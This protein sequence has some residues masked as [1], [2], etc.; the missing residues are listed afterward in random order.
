MKILLVITKAEIG[1]AQMSVFNL[2]KG[3]K[4]RG[5]QVEVIF[6]DGD[7]LPKELGKESI[8]YNRVRFLKRTHNPLASVCFILE[9]YKFLRKNEFDVVHF[10]SSNA[11][12][13]VVGAKLANGKI[14]TIFTFRGMSILDD[15]YR[16]NKCLKNIYFWFFKMMIYFVDVPV[17]VSRR[18][19]QDAEKMGLTKKG[20]L[21][22]NGLD[23]GSL[24]FSEK[25]ETRKELGDRL[26]VSL[27]S[28]YVLGTIGRLCYAKNYEFLINNFN[29]ILKI[30]PN[31]VLL[32]IGEGEEKR[33]YE[34]LIKENNVSEK[35]F[36]MGSIDNASRFIK[37]FDLFVLPSRYEGLS[38]TL[39][40]T[41][42]S[43]IPAL[44][45]DVGGNRENFPTDYELYELD[46]KKEFLERFEKLQNEEVLNK[47]KDINERQKEMFDIKNTVNNYEEIYK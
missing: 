4:K 30:K 12:F 11:L 43:G 29:D 13:G 22:Y 41:L 18:N 14:K 9:M 10:N 5:H 1:G 44:V 6:G 17:F 32:I 37:G 34:K 16:K 40:E 45:S 38:I 15:G 20:V 7:F 28:K 2:A 36:L 25:E 24:K 33:R 46:N 26:G 35:I 8:R 27:S 47:I 31:A 3:L 39:I 21:I 23:F 19:L 42:F